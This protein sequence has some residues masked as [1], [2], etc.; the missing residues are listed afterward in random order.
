[1]FSG[2]SPLLGEIKGD[3]RMKRGVT[4][5]VIVAVAIAGLAC[6][7]HFST[8]KII[9]AQ[10]AREVN[11]NKEAV[12]PTTS[13]DS[14]DQVIHAVVRL[15]AAPEN[16]KVKARWLAVKVEG[17]P[18]HNLVAE[19]SV[20]AGGSN[21]IIDFTLAASETGLPPGDY[22]VDFYLNPQEG[23]ESQPAK[24]LNFTIKASG[25]AIA[26]ATMA[27][28]SDGES[29]STA[30]ASDEEKLYCYVQMRGKT[31]G[32]IVAARWIAVEAQGVDPNFEIDRS[33]IALEGDQNL[34][35]FSLARPNNG[36]PPGKYRVDLYLGDSSEPIRSLPFNVTLVGESAAISDRPVR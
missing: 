35:N 17:I 34:I 10:L 12:D 28:G 23:N 21:N 16:T 25:P 18:Y 1:M 6:G 8:A 4:T 11:K 14:N 15:G 22:K 31:A 36:W 9:E 27:K 20:D 19:T 26:Q 24:T 3:A 32:A 33:Q 5:V 13:F 30:F 2:L 7:F 29:P